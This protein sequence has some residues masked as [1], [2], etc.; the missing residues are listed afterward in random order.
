MDP[1]QPRD[2]QRIVSAYLRIV[3][4]HAAEEIYPGRLRDLP[5]SKDTIRTAFRT[6]TLA[7]IAGG[8]LTEELRDYLEIAYISLADYVEEE[9]AALLTDYRRAGAELA[10]DLRPTRDKTATDA[11]QR[12]T[13]GS[14]LAGEIAQS[15]SVEA[16]RL[17]AEFR[18]WHRDAAAD[19]SAH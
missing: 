2:A 17:R 15:I 13:T 3:E 14:R 6:S 10:A 1:L 9:F 4:A 19:V 18:S 16:D 8:Q 12:V 11:W 5:H 7:L